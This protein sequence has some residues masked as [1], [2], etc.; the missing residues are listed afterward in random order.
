MNFPGLR[1]GLREY[2]TKRMPVQER[3]AFTIDHCPLW[4]FYQRRFE[5]PYGRKSLRSIYGYDFWRFADATRELERFSM[6]QW[7]KFGSDW[8]VLRIDSARS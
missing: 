4:T 3:N 2:T 1:D 5:H 6:K 7:P 8:R